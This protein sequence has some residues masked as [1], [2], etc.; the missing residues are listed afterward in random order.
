[1]IK[2][3]KNYVH[4]G[5]NVEWSEENPEESWRKF[6]KVSFLREKNEICIVLS[7]FSQS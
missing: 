1:M 4:M 5:T 6:F 2:A 7:T 3:S